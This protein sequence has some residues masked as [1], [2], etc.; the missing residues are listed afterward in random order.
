MAVPCLSSVWGLITR[1]PGFSSNGV[2]S[3][4]GQGPKVEAPVSLNSLHTIT[5]IPDQIIV[6]TD[7]EDENSSGP[8]GVR[9]GYEAQKSPI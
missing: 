2:V 3:I 8:S 6:T 9:Q 1:F 7:D 5:Y 4:Q